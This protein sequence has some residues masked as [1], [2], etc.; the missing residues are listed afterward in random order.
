MN[1]DPTKTSPATN[2]PNGEEPSLRASAY[3]PMAASE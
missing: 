2:P 3:I 1:P